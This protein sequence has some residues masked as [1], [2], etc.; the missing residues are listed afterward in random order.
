MQ[1]KYC[2]LS[3]SVLQTGYMYVQSVYVYPTQATTD[4]FNDR[5]EATCNVVRI[6][7]RR[8]LST[9]TG[10]FDELVK[11]RTDRFKKSFISDCLAS[12]Q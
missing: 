9:S 5:L 3:L 10:T 7:D 11:M 6:T 4:I 1:F 2:I 12:Y 8:A